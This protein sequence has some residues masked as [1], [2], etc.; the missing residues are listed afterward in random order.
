MKKMVAAGLISLVFTAAAK[1]RPSALDRHI[2]EAQARSTSASASP[3]SLFT[4]GGL[5]ANLTRDPR[6]SQVD[7]IITIL[8]ADR[9][10]AVS[11]GTLNSSRSSNARYSIGA[12]GGPTRIPGP[13]SDL[14]RFGGERDVQGQG[15]TTRE[16]N[17]TTTLSARVTHVLPNGVMVVEGTKAV[18]INAE[19][20]Q[21]RVRGLIRREDIGA[22]NVVRSDRIA[23]LEISV[24][25]RG[26][27]ADAV[28]RPF[29]LYRILLGVLPF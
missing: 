14:A 25:G 1:E 11:K 18:A 16:N 26:V 23:Q 22:A 7:D 5:L 20:Q 8:V 3:G 28:K 10:S 12:L 15:E 27:V 24:S 29:I 13:L 2:E 21:V 9:A 6:A 17:L 19:M 4:S